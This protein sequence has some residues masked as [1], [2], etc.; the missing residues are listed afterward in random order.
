MRAADITAG[1]WYQLKADNAY[2]LGP[3]YLRVDS[4]SYTAGYKTPWL[5]CSRPLF[6]DIVG[7]FRPSDFSRNYN[8]K[9][10]VS[11]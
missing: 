7:S 6:G 4:I 2:G 11:A 10:K 1:D 8:D 9:R 3:I 5:T